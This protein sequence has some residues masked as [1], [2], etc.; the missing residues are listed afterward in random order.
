MEPSSCVFAGSP[1]PTLPAGTKYLLNENLI[2]DSES[3]SQR[4][5]RGGYSET[6][7]QSN[8]AS[9]SIFPNS[10]KVFLSL[11]AHE[12]LPPNSIFQK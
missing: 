10:G 9:I 3:D 4:V 8:G 12:S 1:V 5:A 6:K 2:Y 11:C 7:L